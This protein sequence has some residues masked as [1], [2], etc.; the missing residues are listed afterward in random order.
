MEIIARVSRG[1]KMDQ[2]YIPKQRAILNIG[3]F[4]VIKPLY[5]QKKKIK[6]DKIYFYGTKELEP[7]KLS[8]IKEL[9]GI[10]EKYVRADNI[11]I[12]GS[13]LHK[14]FDF[15]D[16][17]ILIV[18]ERPIKTSSIENE[19]DEKL[20]IKSHMIILSN[21]SLIKGLE[22]DPLYHTMLSCCVARKRLTPVKKQKI[23]YKLLDMHLLKSRILIDNFDIL[24][25]N[26]KYDLIR[27][28]IAIY[29][30]LKKEKVTIEKIHKKILS[31]FK[32]SSI[33]EIKRNIINKESFLNKFGKIYKE[34]Y[35]K[36]LEGIKNESKQKQAD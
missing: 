31:L 8:I 21:S 30:F 24:N 35:N 7:I 16:I 12:T 2:I 14:G 11:I 13:F 29:L 22:T 26:E 33:S 1:S 18:S 15:N 20:G 28:L 27:N 19:I 17:D 34:T 10:I 36:I 3:E 6:S 25:G 9:V 5:S 32:V 23:N 4:A